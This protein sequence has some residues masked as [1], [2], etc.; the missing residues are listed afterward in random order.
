MSPVDNFAEQKRCV[1][2]KK[3]NGEDLGLNRESILGLQDR[4]S[5]AKSSRISPDHSTVRDRLGNSK[6]AMYAMNVVNFDEPAK[7]DAVVVSVSANGMPASEIP[8]TNMCAD[9]VSRNP[10][11]AKRAL[12]RLMSVPM[13]DVAQYEGSLPSIPL[14]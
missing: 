3:F 1:G 8:T 4:E 13:W 14:G 10:T 7:S 2:F 11:E 9:S 5:E 12:C 6:N